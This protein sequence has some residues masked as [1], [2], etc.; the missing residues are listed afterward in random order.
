MNFVSPVL[1]DKNINLLSSPLF[2][3]SSRTSRFS[4]WFY[5]LLIVTKWA[6]SIVLQACFVSQL[7]K[8]AQP[9]ICMLKLVLKIFRVNVLQI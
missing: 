2:L 8:Q 1:R 3:N 4:C 9:Y 5:K 6:I 7:G